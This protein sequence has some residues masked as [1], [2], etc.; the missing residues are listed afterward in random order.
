MR[1]IKTKNA[2]GAPRRA[3]YRDVVGHGAAAVWLV[4]LSGSGKSTLARDAEGELLAEC[5]RIVVIDGD[6]CREGISSDLGF[7]PAHCTENIRRAAELVSLLVNSGAVV[8]ASFIS[9]LRL[10]RE[11]ARQIIAKRAPGVPFLEVFLAA[12]V[13]TCESRDPKGLYRLARQGVISALAGVSGPFEPC[14]SPDLIIDTAVT[15]RDLAK[16]TLIRRIRS[17]AGVLAC[18]K[19]QLSCGPPD[20]YEG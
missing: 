12:S 4:G 5:W 13:S 7:T 1:R 6:D 15:P 20:Q 9:P 11:L 19:A 2:K 10:H 3:Q 14:Q 16:A 18:P 8:L 17:M